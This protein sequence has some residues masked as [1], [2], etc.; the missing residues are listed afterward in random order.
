MLGFFYNVSLGKKDEVVIKVQKQREAG[1]KWW[2]DQQVAQEEILLTLHSPADAIIG[3]YRLAVLVMSPQGQIM[4]E[5]KTTEFHLLYN[6][7]CKGKHTLKCIHFYPH[8]F[9]LAI[10]QVKPTRRKLS[11]VGLRQYF[12]RRDTTPLNFFQMRVCMMGHKNIYIH[13]ALSLMLL[14][15]CFLCVNIR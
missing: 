1:D 6:P 4:Q 14:M 13:S 9:K 15:P 7:W 5:N 11:I 12:P 10:P 3:Q 8:L 2:F